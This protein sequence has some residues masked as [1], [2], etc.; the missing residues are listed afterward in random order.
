M[1][2]WRNGKAAVRSV[3]GHTEITRIQ[4]RRSPLVLRFQV[5][6]APEHSNLLKL[7]NYYHMLFR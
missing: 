5:A 1:I 7:E 3:C 2:N 6:P 4:S